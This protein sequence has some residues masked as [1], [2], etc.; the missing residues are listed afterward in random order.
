MTITRVLKINK[1]RNIVY[2]YDER[3]ALLSNSELLE[4]GL[5]PEENSESECEISDELSEELEELSY[6]KALPKAVDLLA[7]SDKS[8]SELKRKLYTFGF[9]ESVTER[10]IKK[11]SDRNY[12]DD[13]R[14]AENFIRFNRERMSKRELKM[15]LSEKGISKEITDCYFDDAPDSA[16]MEREACKRILR[17]KLQGRYTD[18]TYLKKAIVHACGKGFEYE[19]VKSCITEIVNEDE[20]T[21]S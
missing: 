3:I 21:D 18:E 12:I 13:N 2:S 19:T 14:L 5:F 10:V 15:K 17:K 7:K 1:N 11:L 16:E 6:K 9:S 8:E 20:N 4:Y